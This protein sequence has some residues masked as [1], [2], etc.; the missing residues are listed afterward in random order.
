[1]L[2]PIAIS[3]SFSQPCPTNLTPCHAL[4]GSHMPDPGLP[5]LASP[6]PQHAVKQERGWAG[7]ELIAPPPL[8]R[9]ATLGHLS[10]TLPASSPTKR[11]RRATADAMRA[12]G[13]AAKD[14]EELA[15]LVVQASLLH[16]WVLHSTV[17]MLPLI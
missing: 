12:A 8:A 11:E 16:T 6:P 17:H 14:I 3:R 2:E 4:K 7:L 5:E 13:T 15:L 9:H 1:M 10:V